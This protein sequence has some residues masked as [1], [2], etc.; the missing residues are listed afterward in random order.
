MM[1]TAAV[2][3][4]LFMNPYH[5]MGD[6]PEVAAAKA[7][8]YLAYI[9]AAAMNGVRTPLPPVYYNFFPIPVDDTP[10]VKAAKT[11]FFIAYNAAL[12]QHA[13]ASAAAAAAAK[14]E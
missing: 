1:L 14:E 13:A 9:T 6:T 2:S 7:Q 11:Q 5:F 3:A 4:Q 8:H 12:A 10:E